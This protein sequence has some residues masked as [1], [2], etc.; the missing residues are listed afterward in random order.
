L[1][2]DDVGRKAVLNDESVVTLDPIRRW[3]VSIGDNV[4]EVGA[5]V[6]KRNPAICGIRGGELARGNG[7]MQHE[8]PTLL[9][10]VVHAVAEGQEAQAVPYIST[11]YSSSSI[12]AVREMTVRAAQRVQAA[13]GV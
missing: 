12:D 2:G 10:V 13:L 9:R 6:E 8:P 5:F 11:S 1:S 3:P 4:H 7:C